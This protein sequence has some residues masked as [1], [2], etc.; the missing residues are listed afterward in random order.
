MIQN[1]LNFNYDKLLNNLSKNKQEF[2][3]SF[4]EDI[5]DFNLIGSFLTEKIKE[6]H[7]SK[8]YDDNLAIRLT[9]KS[10]N[11]LNASYCSI[12]ESFIKKASGKLTQDKLILLCN[13]YNI[14]KNNI[15][16]RLKPSSKEKKDWFNLV[17]DAFSISNLYQEEEFKNIIM[18]IINNRNSYIHDISS[19]V[20]SLD[21]ME[22]I[23]KEVEVRTDA[24]LYLI[25]KIIENN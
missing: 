3:F 1:K 10:I 16:D 7:I 5:R 23:I 17:K 8:A 9:I 25:V 24:V 22:K 4:I 6:N 19:V 13:K 20:Y 15:F 21:N 12:L 11:I 14:H 18:D 2:I